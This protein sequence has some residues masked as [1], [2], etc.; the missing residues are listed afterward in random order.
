MTSEP[1]QRPMNPKS[2]RDSP[3]MSP[4]ALPAPLETSR[5]ILEPLA[6]KHAEVDFSALMS[7]RARLRTE[8][9]WGE[10]PPDDFTVERNRVDLR[11]HFDEFDRG[12]AFAYTVLS[13]D[14]ESCIGCIYLETCAEVDGARLAF[15]VV[16]AAVKIEAEFVAAVLQ[17]LYD[18]WAFERIVLPFRE[19]NT[20]CLDMANEMGL[21]EW[22]P[23]ATETLTGYRC[24]LSQPGNRGAACYD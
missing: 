16:D 10:W 11:R 21:D 22:T 6:E 19:T 4:D 24:F 7:C 12:E 18:A 3:W 13:P 9:Q 15:W 14:R 20:R 2:N 23:T 1:P 8:L 17:W 5:F